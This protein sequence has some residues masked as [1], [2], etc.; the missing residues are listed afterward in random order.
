MLKGGEWSTYTGRFTPEPW[1]P[2]NRRLSG[3]HSQSGRFGEEENL[4][5][6]HMDNF[7]VDGR[8]ILY[9]DLNGVGWGAGA[10]LIWLRIGTGNGRL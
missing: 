8:I 10:G 6:L 4:F 3:P 1:Y 9:M 7:T 2:L 5:S